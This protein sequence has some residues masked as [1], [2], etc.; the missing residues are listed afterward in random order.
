M[1][2]THNSVAII[3]AGPSGLAACKST[4]EVGLSPTVFEKASHLGGLWK[5]HQGI[6]DKML[7][8]LSK[9]SCSFSDFPWDDNSPMFPNQEELL[10][11]LLRYADHFNLHSYILYNREVKNLYKRR[12]KWTVVTEHESA[13][14]DFV[15][16][17]TGIFSKPH[18]PDIKGIEKFSIYHSVSHSHDYWRNYELSGKKVVVVGGSFSGAEIASDISKVAGE[19][20]NIIKYPLWV[21]PRYFPPNNIPVDLCFYS[22]AA[23]AFKKTREAKINNRARNQ[24]FSGILEKQGKICPD[25]YIDPNSEAESYLIISDSYIADIESGKIFIHKA[26]IL[27]FDEQG[28]IINERDEIKRINCDAVVFCT[29]FEPNLDFLYSSIADNIG[30][31][32]KNLLQPI[33]LY[34]S[35][36][37]TYDPTIAFAGVYRGSYFAIMELQSR[38]AVMVFAGMLS[39]IDEEALQKG[40]Q[41]EIEIK[42][43]R[44]TPQFPHPD[45]V[46][47]ADSIAKEIGAL[48]NLEE[49]DPLYS[50]LWNGP[51]IPAH[52]RL[53]GPFSNPDLAKQ[54]IKSAL[55]A[56]ERENLWNDAFNK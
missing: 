27:E 5:G 37:S 49:S 47:F 23:S 42:N 4:L 25:L 13:E 15:I 21:A 35:T 8:N 28:I 54:T 44:P 30:Y 7:T 26:E 24:Y 31:N 34:K 10:S 14:F 38:W 19:V 45:Y 48:P 6:W 56:C 12:D 33:L 53:C 20:H 17:A 50:A 43:K 41:E 1:E 36:F 46:S 39:P 52:Y 40:I 32:P 2:I 55:I 9:F 18:Y 51:L 3:G 29:G 22:R 11:Y 16:I